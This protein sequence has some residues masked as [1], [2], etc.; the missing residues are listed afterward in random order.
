MIH[1]EWQDSLDAYVAGE[2]DAPTRARLLEHLKGCASCREDADALER[3]AKEAARLPRSIEPPPHVWWRIAGELEKPSPAKPVASPARPI[4]SP[5]RFVLAGAL[6][7]AVFGLAT[8]LAPR[9]H[10]S[11]GTTAST[12]DSSRTEP[13]VIVLS[14]EG[15]AQPSEWAQMIWS[16]EKESLSAEKAV[17]APL[18]G[19]IDAEGLKRA[20]AVEPAL[21]ALD[22][23]ITEVA[24]AMRLEPDNTALARTLTDYYERK[25]ELLRVAARL[26]SGPWA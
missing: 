20:S 3:I 9:R 13:G 1:P 26:A 4:G 10:D 15:E 25:L 7:V 12:T 17:F 16:L 5:F 24:D 18:A 21:A 14:N 22:T 23:A 6:L 19:H 11:T 8:L 2:L